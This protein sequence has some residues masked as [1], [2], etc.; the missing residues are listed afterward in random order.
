MSERNTTR[1]TEQQQREACAQLAQ[2]M[3]WTE[4]VTNCVPPIGMRPPGLGCDLTYL[5]NPFTNRDDSA[6]L[7]AWLAADDARWAKLKQQ[8]TALWGSAAEQDLI[9]FALTLPCKTIAE[10]AC[11]ALGIEVSE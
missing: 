9:R 1:D 6:A 2:R 8:L 5:P 3:G 4:V 10:A 7:V 11:K